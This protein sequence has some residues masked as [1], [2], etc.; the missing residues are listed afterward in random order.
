M[1]SLLTFALVLSVSFLASFIWSNKAHRVKRKLLYYPWEEG[2][3]NLPNLVY[4]HNAA[5]MFY[6]DCIINNT[7]EEPWIDIENHQLQPNSLLLALFSKQK[8]KT[9]NFVIDSKLNIWKKFKNTTPRKR[10]L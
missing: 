7:N 9:V 5:Q 4:Y 10:N 3:L 8:N 1:L 6:I 2:D